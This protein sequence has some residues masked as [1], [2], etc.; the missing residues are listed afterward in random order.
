MKPIDPRDPDEIEALLP[1]FVNGTLTTAEAERVRRAVAESPR[2]ALSLRLA[3]EERQAAVAGNEELPGPA[4]AALEKLMR[5]VRADARARS[6]ALRE[7]LAERLGRWLQGLSPAT[8]AWATAAGVALIIGQLGVIGGYIASRPGTTYEVASSQGGRAAAGGAELVVRLRPGGDTARLTRL[9]QDT[10]AVII[11]G[12]RGGGVYRLR[13]E[14]SRDDSAAIERAVASLR[15]E[16]DLI[17]FIARA[18]APTPTP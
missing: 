13:I 11:D 2:L 3:E 6:F 17:E 10:G 18:P 4:P 9:L 1:W 12:P 16:R 15:G 14:A 5:E 8:L 7:Q